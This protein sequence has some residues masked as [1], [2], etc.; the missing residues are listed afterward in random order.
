MVSCLMCHTGSTACFSRCTACYQLC[1]HIGLPPLRDVGVKCIY[2][3]VGREIALP[4][5]PKPDKTREIKRFSMVYGGTALD[6]SV[7]SRRHLVLTVIHSTGAGEAR[8]PP[9]G[10]KEAHPHEHGDCLT[11]REVGYPTSPWRPLCEVSAHPAS[12]ARAPEPL[13]CLAN[14]HPSQ[15]QRLYPATSARNPS[16]PRSQPTPVS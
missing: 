7:A 10:S 13:L 4:D 15:A 5:C 9:N 16:T 3:C 6:L 1:P 14:S 12:R 2:T 8:L 11:G